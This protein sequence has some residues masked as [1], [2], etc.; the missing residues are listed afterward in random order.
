LLPFSF[1]PISKKDIEAL[2]DS[3]DK[4]KKGGG[5]ASS[6]MVGLKGMSSNESGLPEMDEIEKWW[7]EGMND[8]AIWHGGKGVW[9]WPIQGMGSVTILPSPL[10]GMNLTDRWV[11]SWIL[12]R[13]AIIAQGISAR[14]ALG[15][16]S[17]ADAKADNRVF[18]F[19]GRMAWDAKRD[20][21]KEGESGAKL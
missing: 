9:K 1:V 2:S 11:R 13:L 5:G 15:Q 12:F 7:V 14:A 21:D 10:R 20:A 6:L 16:A 8:S 17:S 3:K 18:N 4:D 19:F